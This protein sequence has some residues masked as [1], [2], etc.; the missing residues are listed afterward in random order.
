MFSAPGIAML[1]MLATRHRSCRRCR[2]DHRIK[3]RTVV[4]NGR[5]PIPSASVRA[6]RVNSR[7]TGSA[8]DHDNYGDASASSARAQRSCA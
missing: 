8:L 1:V 7:A 2:Q 3:T 4:S 6:N 5:T